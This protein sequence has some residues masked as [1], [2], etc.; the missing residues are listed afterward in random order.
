MKSKSFVL[1]RG[2]GCLLP[3]LVIF[4]L[5]FG[6]FFLKAAYWL[7]LELVLVVLFLWSSTVTVKKIIS[8]A[9]RHRNGDVID[10]DGEIVDDKEDRRKLAN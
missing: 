10:V 1:S 9:G 3:L 5:F 2:T 6:L 8:S 4:N 7:L